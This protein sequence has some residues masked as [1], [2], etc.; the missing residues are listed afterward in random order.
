VADFSM[1]PNGLGIA[2]WNFPAPEFHAEIPYCGQAEFVMF[3]KCSGKRQRAAVFPLPPIAG[4][5]IF[6]HPKMVRGMPVKRK[7]S[8]IQS[9]RRRGRAIAKRRERLG[10]KPYHLAKAAGVESRTVLALEAGTRRT[11]PSVLDNVM[12][13]LNEA[14]ASQTWNGRERRGGTDRRR[15]SDRRNISSE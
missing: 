14:E 1:F 7:A 2:I 8:Q 10:W 6:R 11:I 12:R 5:R 13:A 3:R 9:L 15:G 4:I